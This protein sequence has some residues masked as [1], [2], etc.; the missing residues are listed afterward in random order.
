MS[1]SEINLFSDTVT[2]PTPEMYQAIVSAPVGDDMSGD[3]PTTNA[4]EAEMAKLL[5]KEAAVFACTATQANQMAIRVHCRSGDELLI[6]P[7]GHISNYEAGGPA[8]LSGVSCRS[9]PGPHGMPDLD[10]LKACVRPI[11]QHFTPTRLLCVENTTNL[12]GGRVWPLDRLQAVTEWAR[13]QAFKTH[14]D[15]AR[16]FNAVVAL[17]CDPAEVAQYVDTVTVCFSKGLGCPMGAILAG[18]E[19]EIRE[20]RRYRKLFGGALR[21]SGVVAAAARYAL[22][23][24]VERLADDHSNARFLAE[25]LAKID[26]IQVDVD[27]IE[28]NL[29]FFEIDPEI[30]TA[31]QMSA[32]LHR[33]GLRIGALGAY[34]LRAVT[35]L[36]VT[37]ED[38]SQAA[39]IV[40]T[41]VREGLSADI[42]PAVQY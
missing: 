12:G 28:T 14:M 10:E 31:A 38:M 32:E 29:V 30:G 22:Q 8:A 26:G 41:A 36:D 15:G 11:D 27:A 42:T 1:D 25:R 39:E 2:R 4:L 24:H 18:T 6:H 23:S 9:I 20:A 16:F 17:G 35:H 5:G 13:G 21:Q 33:R 3:D 34:R 19:A 40:Q 37:R 7:T